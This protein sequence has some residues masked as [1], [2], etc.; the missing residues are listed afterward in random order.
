MPK[1]KLLICAD[2]AC[3][4]AR[5]FAYKPLV[6]AACEEAASPPPQVLIV[7]RGLDPAMHDIVEGRDV[8]YATLRAKYE[9]AQVDGGMAG[10]ER[11]QLPALHLRHHRQA[12]GRAARRRRLCGGAGAVDVDDLR[13]ARRA[14][15]VLHFRCRL[16]GRAFV[17]RLRAADRRR[18]LGAVRRLPTNPDPGIWWRICEQYGVRTMFSSPTGIRVLKK[19]DSGVADASTT[20]R[21]CTGCSSPAS[22]WTNRPR[23]GSPTARQDRSSTTTGRPKPAGRCCRLMPG[24][25]MKPVKFGSPGLPTPGYKLNV[26]DDNSGE[27]VAAGPEGRAGD[28]AAAAAGLPDHGLERRRAFPVELLQPLQGTGVQLAGLGDPRRGRLHLHPRPHRR[29]DQRRRAS[30]GH[31]RDR[32]VRARRIPALPRPR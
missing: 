13:R 9:G 17:Q 18:D 31:A 1:P 29:R 2:A 7:S 15:D 12:Q 26:I 32:G 21:S 5:S 3:A 19:Q 27:D 23:T 24:L 11:T 14:G 16:G 6:D 20:C 30:P 28:R 10:I 8:D 25:D 4:A 22:R